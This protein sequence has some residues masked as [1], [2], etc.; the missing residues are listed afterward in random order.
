MCPAGELCS[1]E[2]LR[3]GCEQISLVHSC[4]GKKCMS[5]IDTFNNVIHNAR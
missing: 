1:V 3:A 4:N 5:V 2:S